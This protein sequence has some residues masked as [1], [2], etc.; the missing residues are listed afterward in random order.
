MRFCSREAVGLEGD[1]FASSTVVGE[2]EESLEGDPFATEEE[3]DEGEQYFFFLQRGWLESRDQIRLTDGRTISARQR[4][5][6][7]LGDTLSQESSSWL[8]SS[9]FFLSS[10]LDFDPANALSSDQK[11][12][13]VEL[14]ESYL[15]FEGKKADL[16][17]G[18]KM[19]R[20]GTGDGINPLDLLNPVD[21]QDPYATGRSDNRLPV[22]LGQEIVSLPT[23]Q[24]LQELTL[25]LVIVPLAEVNALPASGSPWETSGLKEL[26]E[27]AESGGRERR[28]RTS[29]TGEADSL[30]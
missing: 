24:L 26:R 2:K 27:A 3:I 23:P 6:L 13:A 21:M 22:L 9:R 8:A 14:H 5:W 11:D 4:L 1:P 15:T 17:L 18:K 20:W 10:S 19:V 29:G 7:E 25:E 12:L 16:L 30:V 28:P